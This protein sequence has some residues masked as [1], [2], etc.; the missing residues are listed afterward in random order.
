VNRSTVV[1]ILSAVLFFSIG[2]FL[3]ESLVPTGAYAAET[4]D[5]NTATADELKALLGIGV[6]YAKKIIEGRPYKRKDGLVQ[7]KIV[8]RQC[9][10]GSKVKLWRSRSNLGLT[11][12]RVLTASIRRDAVLCWV[13]CAVLWT[14]L[15]TAY[16]RAAI[17]VGSV[18]RRILFL[19]WNSIATRTA[20]EEECYQPNERKKRKLPSHAQ[21]PWI[22]LNAMPPLHHT[23]TA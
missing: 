7:K 6:A 21:P 23:L 17:G 15:L 1:C 16:V 10:T 14:I 22:P 4:L 3:I 9:T 8:R 2:V 5:I 12:C 19:S 20:H 18:A 13:A 11:A